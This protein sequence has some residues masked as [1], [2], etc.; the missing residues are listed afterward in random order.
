M[1]E[2]F[3][4]GRE[5]FGM[6]QFS[7][8]RRLLERAAMAGVGGAFTDL[9]LIALNGLL[10][11]PDRK[12]AQRQF[13][14]GAQRNDAEAHYW[15]ALLALSDS[16][17]GIASEL[18]RKHFIAA[19]Q[20]RFS[21]ALR[22]FSLLAARDAQFFAVAASAWAQA[23]AL[24][25]PFAA[26]LREI[27]AGVPE[28][29]WLQADAAPQTPSA[30]QIEQVLLWQK[31]ALSLLQRGPHVRFAR[32]VLSPFACWYL[33]TIAA[34]KLQPALVKDP[35]SGVSLRSPLRTNL[36]APLGPD[37]ADLAI[38][39]IEHDIAQFAEADLQRAEPIAVLCY[40]V[41]EEY[42]PHRDYLH[43]AKE[44]YIDRPGQRTRTAFCY[45]N[46]VDV[47]GETEFLHWNQRISPE[48]GAVVVFDNV[49]ADGQPEPDSV[50]AGL[51]VQAGEKWLATLWFR[52]RAM[53]VW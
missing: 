27:A 46:A 5:A 47:G 40:R 49:R 38:R 45:L 28:L 39:L 43:D 2:D 32:G 15:L 44:L 53:R 21:G 52:E 30:R 26:Q 25:D 4:R 48:A 29:A 41:G 6:G 23:V 35:R 1:N 12:Q 14:E 42:K 19:I 10:E 33:R 20:G 37:S 18:F 8:A 17:E 31:P 51:A 50:H 13:A 34:P 22:A 24:R 11:A 9:G 7:R 3:D 36:T 16:P